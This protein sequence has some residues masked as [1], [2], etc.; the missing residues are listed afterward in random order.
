MQN[1]KDL[2]NFVIPNIDSVGINN[3]KCGHRA[4]TVGSS[5]SGE[6]VGLVGSLTW[7]S[8]SKFRCMLNTH[9]INTHSMYNYISISYICMY[10]CMY[11]C[12]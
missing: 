4:V 6:P 8:S 2:L 12:M 11:V 10:V 7:V 1:S 9:S 3:H 5:T